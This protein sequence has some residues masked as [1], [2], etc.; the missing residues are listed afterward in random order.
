MLQKAIWGNGR[1]MANATYWKPNTIIDEAAVNIGFNIEIGFYSP[2]G[3]FVGSVS[4]T[5]DGAGYIN[6]EIQE[7]RVGG[8]KSFKFE[9]GRQVDIPFYPLLECRFFISGIH[10]YTGE[11]IFKPNQDRREITY[12]YS[13][14]GFWDYAKRI[15]MTKTYANKTMK[16]IIDDMIQNFLEPESRVIYNP[17]LIEPPD[18]TILNFEIKKKDIQKTILRLLGIANWDY[19]NTQYITGVD[20]NRHFYFRPIDTDVTYSYYEGFQYQNPDVKEDLKKVIN[21]V[22]VYRAKSGSSDIEE[23]ATVNDLDSQGRYGI[24]DQ[25]ITIPIF[26]DTQSA[27]KIA[28]F[29]IEKHKSP[30]ISVKVKNLETENFPF[31]IEY[32]YINNKIDDYRKIIA[33]FELLAE[34]TINI[35]QT[36]ITTT[37]DKVLSGR[38]SFKCVTQ[39]GSKD[40]YIEQEY[41]EEVN[42]PAFLDIWLAQ[43]ENEIALKIYIWD[44]K[45]NLISQNVIVKIVNDFHRQRIDVNVLDNIKK[46][47]IEFISNNENTIYF[48]RLELI[49]KSWLRHDLILDRI[50]YRLS[51]SKLLAEATYGNKVDTLVDKIKKIKDRQDDIFDIYEKL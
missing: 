42:L 4:T 7:D 37:T 2:S 20:V 50:K 9:I 17:S 39:N 3:E 1:I 27:I 22:T 14:K 15:K 5:P 28:Q 38:K 41:D 44:D 35:S 23:V 51:R 33:E 49:T 47:R 6:F 34:W 16:F 29:I 32:Y 21:K 19:N 30:L 11:L 46:I 36:I 45:N 12:K 48:D 10:W 8:L 24:M 18:I 13:G 43:L 40:D 31:P 26:L 25:N